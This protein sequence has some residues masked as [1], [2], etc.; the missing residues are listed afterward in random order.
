MDEEA[1]VVA[2]RNY[3]NIREDFDMI[4]GTMT[5]CKFRIDISFLCLMIHA[6]KK[7]GKMIDNNSEAD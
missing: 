7:Q 2:E 3:D 4:K 1:K 5:E 6:L